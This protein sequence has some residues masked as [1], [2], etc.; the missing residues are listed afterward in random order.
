MNQQY[1]ISI[2]KS[3]YLAEAI[4]V[5][6]TRLPISVTPLKEGPFLHNILL[7]SLFAHTGE[8]FRCRR[9]YGMT[10]RGTVPEGGSPSMKKAAS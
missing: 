9:V 8:P 2:R 5:D 3:A 6:M 7:L 4:L 1:P 10:G